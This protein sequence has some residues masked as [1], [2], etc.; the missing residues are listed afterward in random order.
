[1]QRCFVNV[2]L[3][4]FGPRSVLTQR[5][6]VSSPGGAPVSPRIRSSP[7]FSGGTC[8]HVAFSTTAYGVKLYTLYHHHPPPP[9][10]G[11]IRPPLL[12]SP[13][14]TSVCDFSDDVLM[15]KT[16]R[17]FYTML[18]RCRLCS[19][20]TYMLYN[21]MYLSKISHQNIFLQLS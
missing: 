15:D 4:K 9:L 3:N 8:G 1:M 10:V 21:A 17:G 12:P 20:S 14:P 7:L 19:C 11:P 16:V 6:F 5:Y 18:L 2:I 13:S